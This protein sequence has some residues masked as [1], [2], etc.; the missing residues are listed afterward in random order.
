MS[1]LGACFWKWKISK[2][3]TGKWFST[4]TRFSKIIILTLFF[5]HLVHWDIS[6]YRR[7]SKLA[8]LLQ[9]DDFRKSSLD[10]KW[11]WVSDFLDFLLP[12]TCPHMGHVPGENFFQKNELLYREP[13][14]HPVVLEQLS[15]CWSSAAHLCMKIDELCKS[16]KGG[17]PI[18]DQKFWIFHSQ[19]HPP[20]L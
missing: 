18:W 5:I 15:P 4:R 2:I 17:K 11:L 10:G 20:L 12:K 14:W 7:S 1:M 19:K 13:K 16:R 8:T 3:S 9:I 6:P